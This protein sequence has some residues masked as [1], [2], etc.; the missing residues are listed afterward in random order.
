MT[1]SVRVQKRN[2]VPKAVVVANVMT[3]RPIANDQL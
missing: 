3:N 2:P 1:T